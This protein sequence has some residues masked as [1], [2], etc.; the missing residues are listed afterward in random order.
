MELLGSSKKQHNADLS[1]PEKMLE[2]IFEVRD[3]WV[4]AGLD[5]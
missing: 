1:Q 4:D 3:R 2:Y 5:V